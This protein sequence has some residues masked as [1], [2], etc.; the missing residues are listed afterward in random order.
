MSKKPNPAQLDLFAPAAGSRPPLLDTAAAEAAFVAHIVG[1]GLC[2]SYEYRLNSG[3]LWHPYLGTGLPLSNSRLIK[4]PMQCHGQRVYLV[5]PALQYDTW[6]SDVSA[7]LGYRPR[8][9][10][11]VAD[12]RRSSEWHH[13]TDLCTKA[14]HEE[15]IATLHFTRPECVVDSVASGLRYG[16]SDIDAKIARKLLEAA[17]IAEPA[18]ADADEIIHRA[19]TPEWNFRDDKPATAWM[20]V[21]GL[22]A[23]VTKRGKKPGAGLVPV[24]ER[25]AA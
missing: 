23:G 16:W 14:H 2:T 8:Y 11:C 22:E 5:H 24:K 4:F 3:H 1:A 13:A 17:G 19:T 6:V 9:D 20:H 15:L 25:I 18:I 12:R 7:K 21:H 10:A